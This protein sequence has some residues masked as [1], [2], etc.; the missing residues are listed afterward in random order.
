MSFIFLIIIVINA[1]VFFIKSSE[2]A[3]RPVSVR[4]I[5]EKKVSN[6]YFRIYIYLF[7]FVLL[8]VFLTHNTCW[9]RNIIL[10]YPDNIER[11]YYRRSK[12]YTSVFVQNI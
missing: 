9:L 1:R 2:N 11:H 12:I 6:N 10:N 3:K 7:L 8:V 5:R 4:C